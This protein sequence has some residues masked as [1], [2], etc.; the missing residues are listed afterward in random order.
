MRCPYYATTDTHREEGRHAGRFLRAASRG[1]DY[2]HDEPRQGGRPAGQG[3][4]QS[5]RA[6]TR[7][8]AAEVMLTFA[9]N[10][11]TKANG[12]GTMDPAVWQEQIEPV[13]RARPVHQARAQARR[14]DDARDPERDAR[15]AAPRSAE[16]MAVAPAQ[17]A[18]VA[19]AE[20]CLRARHGALHDRAR[21]PSPRSRASRLDDAARQL[22]D[23]ARPV[24]LRQVDL[25]RVI[26]DLIAP[27][28]RADRGA[29][30]D[31]GDGAAQPRDRLR[32]P[33]R[34]AAAVAHRARERRR[35]R[36][37]SAGGK[38]CRRRAARRRTC[39][40]WSA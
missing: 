18:P 17:A 5:Q 16:P 22:P 29:G 36:S 1:W 40:R 10:A 23:P 33:G 38:R 12:W 39:W 2:A 6:P 26:A 3:I 20:P 11:N 4:P 21:A 7:S 30:R 9:F 13:R 19:S 24:G 28:R 34:R 35:C 25:L 32:V 8:R 31:A 37:R 14:G 15:A 27:I